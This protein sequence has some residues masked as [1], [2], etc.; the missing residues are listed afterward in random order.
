MNEIA[1]DIL[2]AENDNLIIAIVG[3]IVLVVVVTIAVMAIVKFLRIKKIGPVVMSEQQ[4]LFEKQTNFIACQHF[5]DDEIHD[6]DDFVRS[7]CQ[8][9][10]QSL[11]LHIMG[12]LRKYLTVGLLQESLTAH[13]SLLFTFSVIKNHFTKELMPDRFTHY[14]EKLIMQIKDRYSNTQARLQSGDETENQLPEWKDVEGMFLE[15]IDY[16][17]WKLYDIV[18]QACVDKI[19]VYNRYLIRFQGS[20]HHLNICNECI[21]KNQNYIEGLKTSYTRQYPNKQIY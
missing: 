9:V 8:S 11:E 13:M 2:T 14:R 10:V 21:K 5:M 3:I 4:A 18:N 20:E 7:E 17:L 16:W 1:H 15:I 12:I 6:I 19:E